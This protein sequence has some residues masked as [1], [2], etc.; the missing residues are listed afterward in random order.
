[1]EIS[2]QIFTNVNYYSFNDNYKIKDASIQL[3]EKRFNFERMMNSVLEK[4]TLKEP[5]NLDEYTIGGDDTGIYM[6]WYCDNVVL[7]DMCNWLNGCAYFYLCKENDEARRKRCIDIMDDFVPRYQKQ[8]EG[9]YDTWN[10]WGNNW[11]Q[12]SISSTYMLF[13]YMLI[14][15]EKRRKIAID[16]ILSIIKTPKY[17]LGKSRDQANSVYMALPWIMA[18]YYKGEEFIKN[19]S[20]HPDYKYVVNYVKLEP[21]KK[22]KEEGLYLDYTYITHTNCLAYGYLSEMI[23]M[24]LP[25]IYFDNCMA[26]FLS[27]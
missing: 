15:G 6:A 1:M 27:K 25:L 7:G 19:A 9:L 8:M 18:H 17:S 12:F 3:Q 11:Y 26:N 2:K 5:E 14:A 4:S 16:V 21:V 20:E 10:P 13:L 22:S 23:S 24:S